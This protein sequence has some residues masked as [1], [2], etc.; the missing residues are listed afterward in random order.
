MNKDYLPAHNDYEHLGGW[1]GLLIHPPL[2]GGVKCVL[3]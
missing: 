2:K 1:K 3:C